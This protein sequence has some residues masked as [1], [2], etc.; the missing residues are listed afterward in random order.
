MPASSNGP[1]A[2][3]KVCDGA[4]VVSGA[5]SDASAAP[6]ERG[7]RRDDEIRVDHRL[8]GMRMAGSEYARLKARFPVEAAEEHAALLHNGH[9]N[10]SA[11]F[12]DGCD[13]AARI[14]L[15]AHRPEQGNDPA[16]G[17]EGVKPIGGAPRRFCAVVGAKLCTP[18]QRRGPQFGFGGGEGDHRRKASSH[19][20]LT[21]PSK[22]RLEQKRGRLGRWS[23]DPGN[24]LT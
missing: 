5:V 22:T 7:E 1:I 2:C 24:L 15:V 16:A 4:I 6:V 19:A 13:Q 8:A 12:E 3:D 21:P 18:R 14:D 17:Y 10:A 11:G 9:C 20:S 23:F